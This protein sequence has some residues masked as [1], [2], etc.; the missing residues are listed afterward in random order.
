MYTVTIVSA[1]LCVHKLNGMLELFF[2]L[3]KGSGRQTKRKKFEQK[4]FLN[5]FESITNTQMTGSFNFSSLTSLFLFFSKFTKHI[6]FLWKIEKR[7]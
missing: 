5:G 1:S 3:V 6:N 2:R 4:L 7:L